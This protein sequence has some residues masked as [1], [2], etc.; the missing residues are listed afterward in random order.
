MEESIKED[1]LKYVWHPFHQSKVYRDTQLLAVSGEGPYLI[2]DKGVRLLDAIS[3]LW[4][5]TLG[6]SES[7]ISE[8][9]C[10]QLQ[11]LPAL[12][13]IVGSHEP[14]VQLARELSSRA[15]GQLKHVF[16]TSGGSEATETA[17]KLARHTALVRGESLRQNILAFRGSYHGMS[18]GAL[19]ATGVTEDRWQFGTL[20]PNFVHVTSPQS[21]LRTGEDPCSQL[22]AQRCLVEIERALSFHDPRTFAAILLEPVMGVGGMIPLGATILN[23]VRQICDQHGILL[24]FDEVATG[25]GR[26]GTFFAA[27]EVGVVPDMML[28]AKALSSGYLPIGAVLISQAIFDVCESSPTAAFMHGFTFGGSP[29]ACAAA[30]AV[31]KI[32]DEDALLPKVK[33]DGD[34]LLG[35]FRNAFR[36]ER[37]VRNI[38]GVGLMLAFDVFDPQKD[39]EPAQRELGVAARRIARERG[40]I[41]RST[42]GGYTFNFA[43]PFICNK[44]ELESIA[45]VS[46]YAIKRAATELA[47]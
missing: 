41:I 9:I 1:D 19:S 12:S 4:S 8:S 10:R 29:A 31:L 5:V 26:T 37:Y 17:I 22:V 25:C 6:Y 3:S 23:N 11:R 47:S 35:A 46:H 38:R 40:I 27:Q 18:Y 14:A 33:A 15:P 16:F 21:L 43:P 44:Q 24:I 30:Q 39:T 36:N 28:L 2:D 20:L 34:L 13:L 42:Y 45:E 32:I 7:R